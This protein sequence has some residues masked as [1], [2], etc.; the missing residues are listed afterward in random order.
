[1][2]P[3]Y[4]EASGL[5]AS[6]TRLRHYLDESFPSGLWSPSSTTAALTDRSGRTPI[7]TTIDGVDAL[8]LDRKGRGYALRTAWSASEAEVVA[9]MDVDLSTSLRPCSL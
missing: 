9:Y 4:N 3:V 6:I 2:V 7:V 8:I 1:M 5:E